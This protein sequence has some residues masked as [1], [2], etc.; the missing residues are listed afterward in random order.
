MVLV[1]IVPKDSLRT[2]VVLQSGLQVSMRKTFLGGKIL[3]S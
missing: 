3:F 1:I 2:V